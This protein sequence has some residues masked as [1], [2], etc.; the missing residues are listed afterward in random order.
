MPSW[1]EASIP[2]AQITAIGGRLSDTRRDHR[3]FVPLRKCLLHVTRAA[4]DVSLGYSTQAI[5]RSVLM[6]PSRTLTTDNVC[7]SAL[8]ADFCVLFQRCLAPPGA[9]EIQICPCP[10]SSVAVVHDN[11]RLPIA[12][13]VSPEGRTA[14]RQALSRLPLQPF[15]LIHYESPR[16][17]TQRDFLGLAGGEYFNE[18]FIE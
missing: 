1:W 14:T 16:T 3:R 15:K 13:A 7:A 4:R 8:A 11:H 10:V 6:V 17:G 12:S 9:D 18:L 5:T 2:R